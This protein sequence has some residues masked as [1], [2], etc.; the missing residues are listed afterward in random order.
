MGSWAE[1]LQKGIHPTMTSK[2]SQK[3]LEKGIEILSYVSQP[4]ELN[5]R[6]TLLNSA[7]SSLN[8]QDVFQ[9]SR[10]AFSEECK[11][12]DESDPTTGTTINLGDINIQSCAM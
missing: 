2:S 9:Y 6:E 5:D 1:L 3:S 12:S 8:S 11:C 7:T 10:S 4:V